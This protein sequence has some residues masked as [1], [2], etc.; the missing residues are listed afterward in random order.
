MDH[1]YSSCQFY[2]L[3]FFGGEWGGGRT[4]IV[5]VYINVFYT[6]LC[7]QSHLELP[8]PEAGLLLTPGCGRTAASI[9]PQVWSHYLNRNSLKDRESLP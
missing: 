5:V 9:P 6:S 1:A 4:L 2:V 8:A 3:S 7:V